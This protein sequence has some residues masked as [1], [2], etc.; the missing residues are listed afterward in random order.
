LEVFLNSGDRRAVFGEKRKLPLPRLNEA[1]PREHVVLG[2][3]A[4]NKDGSIGHYEKK[5]AW[6]RHE[7]LSPGRII[8]CM[9]Q[10]TVQITLE[11]THLR[12][13]DL[14]ADI[15]FSEF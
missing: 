12:L 13:G 1:D 9:V 11:E 8:L 5:I 14:I 3:Q 15:S 7:F 6:N 4:Y 2:D 10:P